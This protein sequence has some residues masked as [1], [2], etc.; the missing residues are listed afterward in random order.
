MLPMTGGYFLLRLNALSNGTLDF[1]A[2][3]RDGR[4]IHVW[5]V[6]AQAFHALG[7]NVLG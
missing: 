6:C 1:V 7:S 4:N 3:L 5:L 2:D